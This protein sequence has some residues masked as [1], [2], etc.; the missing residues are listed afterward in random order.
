MKL[1]SAR[2]YKHDL[3]DIVGI[4]KEHQE[5]QKPIS[6][7]MVDTAMINLYGNWDKVETTIKE[8]FIKLLNDENLED[9]YYKITAREQDS[10]IVL[11]KAME[12]YSD[13]INDNNVNLFIDHFDNEQPLL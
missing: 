11:H 8:V 13:K 4:L 9:T 6:F 7:E 3:S 12:K 5:L 10:R 1:C 2:T